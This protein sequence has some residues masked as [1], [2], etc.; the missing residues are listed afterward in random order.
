MSWII[1]EGKFTYDEFGYRVEMVE[2]AYGWR[3]YTTEPLKFVFNHTLY[4]KIKRIKE[5]ERGQAIQG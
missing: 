1:E 3:K 5:Q 2:V 4:K